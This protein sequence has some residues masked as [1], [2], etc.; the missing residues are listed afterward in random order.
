MDSLNKAISNKYVFCSYSKEYPKL[1]L[2]EKKFISKLLTSI[3][4]KEIYHIGSTSVPKLG[5]KRILDIIVLVEKK[6]FKKAK[7]LLA[8]GEFIYHHTMKRKRSFHFKYYLNK[9]KKPILVHLHLTYFGS[10][11]IEKA[12]AFRDYLSKF[13]SVRKQYELIKKKASSLHSKDGKKYVAFKL[14]FIESTMKKALD[15]YNEKRLIK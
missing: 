1:F 12:L 4:K 11:E 9:S 7:P 3:K 5:G 10:G 2:K 8:K 13:P 15:W 14:E 6:N